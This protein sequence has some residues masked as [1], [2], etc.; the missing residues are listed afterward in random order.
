MKKKIEQSIGNTGKKSISDSD[1]R[2]FTVLLEDIS[3]KVT[4]IAE[5]HSILDNKID[6][7]R[8]ELGIVKNDLK[9]TQKS[10]GDLRKEL[11]QEITDTKTELK[12]DISN[13]SDRVG[14]LE[15]TT[16]EIRDQV[17][18]FHNRLEDHESRITG[19]EKKTETH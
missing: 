6:A 19:L 1:S 2:R 13:L 15:S 17:K 11:K 14:R 3:S 18:T 7:V 9:S 5:G 10:I 12:Q 16:V 8:K 4:L